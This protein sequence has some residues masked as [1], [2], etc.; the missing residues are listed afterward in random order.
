MVMKIYFKIILLFKTAERDMADQRNQ[1]LQTMLVAATIM[2][3]AL[4][5]GL[6]QVLYIL[7]FNTYNYY[8]EL[9]L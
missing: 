2:I 1:Q 9:F 7:L 4:I 3:I 5:S 8:R 6:I